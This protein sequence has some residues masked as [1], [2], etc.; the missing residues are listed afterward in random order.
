LAGKS[1]QVAPRGLDK[2]RRFWF[3]E[4]DVANPEFWLF[5]EPGDLHGNRLALVSSLPKP[6]SSVSTYRASLQILLLQPVKL[7]CHTNPYAVSFQPYSNYA[8]HP[9]NASTWLPGLPAS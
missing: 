2:G 1:E 8:T 3:D 4:H 6:Y 5:A 9:G 7:T